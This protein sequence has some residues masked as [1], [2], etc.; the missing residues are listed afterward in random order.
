MSTSVFTLLNHIQTELDVYGYKLDLQLTDKIHTPENFPCLGYFNEE[1]KLLSV[2]LQDPNWLF[3]LVHE[4]CHFR[5]QIEGKWTDEFSSSADEQFEKWLKHEIELSDFN[6]RN[7]VRC[8]QECE[9]D[10][11]ERT[12][13]I[14][15]AFN[16]NFN[17]S[18]Y[19]QQANKYIASYELSRLFRT[20][21]TFTD[22]AIKLFPIDFSIKALSVLPT[23]ALN[24]IKKR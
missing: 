16:I 7:I 1:E 4:Y 5:Q 10:C 9:Q 15:K 23:D 6:V 17:C 24:Y 8:I 22:E 13:K 11:E 21:M 3:T 18:L 14:L 12:V 20:D 19:I 2:A